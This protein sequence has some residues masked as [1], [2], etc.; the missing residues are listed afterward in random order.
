MERLYNCRDNLDFSLQNA[1]AQSED[2]AADEA[3]KKQVDARVEQFIQA[4]D[5]DL[6]T[7]DGIAALFDLVRDINTF[8]ASPKAKEPMEYA[9]QQFDRL[10]DVLGCLLYTSFALSEEISYEGLYRG[11]EQNCQKLPGRLHL[12]GLSLGA[13]LAL[14]YTIRHPQRVESL[15]LIAGQY[16]SP[17]FLPVSYTHLDVYKRQRQSCPMQ[18]TL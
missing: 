18:G 6:N 5:D 12:C 10:A 15:V 7:A 13:V 17:K 2:A 3:F 9:A 11:W 14:D 1:L 4:M 16:R 8:L